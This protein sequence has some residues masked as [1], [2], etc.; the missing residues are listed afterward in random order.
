ME[1]LAKAKTIL[2]SEEYTCV[3][4][5][6]EKTYTS[7]E[8]GVKPLLNWI[9]KGIDIKEGFVADKV[10]G[11]AAAFLYVLLEVKALYVGVI[12]KPALEVC[13]RYGIKV[14]Y[15]ELV[16]SIRN[17]DNTGFCPMETAVMGIDTPKEAYETIISTREQISKKT[18][19]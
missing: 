4:I 5:K 16:E 3:A 2:E 17:R 7:R 6:G 14:E 9:E 18:N 15:G 8:R 10:V 1:L 12:S 19:I 11:R 13:N